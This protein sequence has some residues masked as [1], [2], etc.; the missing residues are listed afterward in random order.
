MG[1]VLT[2]SLIGVEQSAH[3][4]HAS[5]FC[6]RCEEV[7]PMKIPL[8]KMMRHYRT[9]AHDRGYGSKTSRIGLTLWSYL[10]SRPTLYRLVTGLAARALAL[11][12][13]GSGRL[14]WVPLAGG[15]TAA[16]DLP[17][18]EGATFMARYR[19]ERGR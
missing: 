5:T 7:C 14:R 19:R 12:G 16:R 13:G 1:A 11:L 18:P 15:W 17:A 3:L 8:P 9:Q 6:G 2:P 4:P 10:A